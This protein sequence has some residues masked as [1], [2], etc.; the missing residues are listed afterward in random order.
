MFIIFG[1]LNHYPNRGTGDI[2]FEM[3][4]LELALDKA[5]STLGTPVGKFDSIEWVELYDTAI[6]KVLYSANEDD[7]LDSK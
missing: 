6:K 2:L 5:K 1:G 3:D 7:D 4:N